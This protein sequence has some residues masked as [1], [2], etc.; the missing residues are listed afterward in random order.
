MLTDCRAG[1]GAVIKRAPELRTSRL[2]PEA[3]ISLE[4]IGTYYTG[5]PSTRP[6]AKVELTRALNALRDEAEVTAL[7]LSGDDAGAD[8][9]ELG[10][11]LEKLEQRC[12][13]LARTTR[14]N[15]KPRLAEARRHFHEARDLLD[16]G[17]P[18]DAV[19]LEVMAGREGLR[20]KA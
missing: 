14:G 17:E 18:T 8:L 3:T 11:A 15:W 1:I 5:V 7:R 16:D 10:Q 19:A 6:P 2:C 4:G 13:D 12:D 9:Q 20:G